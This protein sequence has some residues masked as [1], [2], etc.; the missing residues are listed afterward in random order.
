MFSVL[1]DGMKFT[2]F[3]TLKRKNLPKENF[4]RELY[5]HVMRKDR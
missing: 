2:L 1:A 4:Q 3:V 5:L